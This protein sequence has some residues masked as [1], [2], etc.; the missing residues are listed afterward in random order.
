[1]DNINETENNNSIY[2]KSNFLISIKWKSTLLENKLLATALSKISEMEI[3]PETKLMCSRMKA[4]ELKKIFKGN[5]GSFYK[6][7]DDTAKVMTGRVI[8]MT[9]PEKK[10]FTYL[11][12][13]NSSDYR[14]G[15]FTIVWNPL[16]KNYLINLE[17]NFTLLN[18]G[19][20]VSFKNTWSFRLYELLKSR[21]FN[22]KDQDADNCHFEIEYFLSELKFEIGVANVDVPGVKRYLD[23]KTV[24]KD[25]FDKALE[26]AEKA[27]EASYV[28]WKEFKRKVLD[29]A[30][31]EIN[32]NELSELKVSYMP[33]RSGRGGK[34]IGIKFC[35]DINKAK[36]E[37]KIKQESFVEL[38]EDDIFDAVWD[39]LCNDFKSKEVREI[40]KAANNDIG[41]IKTAYEIL[42][43][44]HG[45]IENKMG[46]ILSAIKNGYE[47]PKK[48]KAKSSFSTEMQNEYDFEQLEKELVYK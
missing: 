27:K 36:A 40:I 37:K 18:L 43:S 29:V 13:V 42:N 6:Q 8:G 46:F 34:I 23:K 38:T 12:I 9:N 2:K 4:S 25:D 7:L 5:S 11:N 28:E 35:V 48:K 3:D 41:K 30:T 15:V 45:H 20:M 33:Q 22:R 26:I 31:K 10:M 44:Q 47:K 39:I 16:L 1:M 24:T 19:L 14:D 17:N 32:E 21:A